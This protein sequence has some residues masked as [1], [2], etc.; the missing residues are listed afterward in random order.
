[1]EEKHQRNERGMCEA[2]AGPTGTPTST[3]TATRTPTPPICLH[4][5][6]SGRNQ[7]DYC[8]NLCS[9]R[10]GNNVCQP[11]PMRTDTL[12]DA[13][14][15]H[16]Y[17]TAN[18]NDTTATGAQLTSVTDAEKSDAEHAHGT[19][20]IDS[21]SL[22]ASDVTASFDTRTK[23]QVH[24]HDPK[25]LGKF[26][27]LLPPFI[28]TM[29]RV[30]WEWFGGMS[31]TIALCNAEGV[32]DATCT[33]FILGAPLVCTTSLPPKTCLSAT[34]FVARDKELL[35]LEAESGSV[36]QLSAALTVTAD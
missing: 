5:G 21:G 2:T 20:G 19:A 36:S 35:V 31:V 28:G 8:S 29:S 6:A 9:G 24:I 7:G 25:I 23:F 15:F 17:T 1:M 22:P 32:G 14:V 33:T 4:E 12:T 11:E 13:S 16:N 3:P 10:G 26:V 18:R 30:D 34:G 27:N